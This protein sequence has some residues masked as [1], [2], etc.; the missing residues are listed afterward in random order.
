MATV[1]VFTPEDIPAA[2]ALFRRVHPQPQWQPEG[3]LESYFRRILFENPWRDLQLPSWAAEERGRLVGF[4]AVMP[5]RMLLSGRVLRVA[6]GCQFM[7]D[8]QQCDALTAF[9]LGKVFLSGPQ[10]L[11]LADGATDQSRRMWT[12]I[13][14]TASL[15][16]S[17]HW[18]RPLRPARYLLRLL[19]RHRHALRPLMLAA[20]PVTAAADALAAWLPPNRVYRQ[21]DGLREDLL[22]VPTML[23]CLPAMLDGTALRPLYDAHSLAWLLDE[24]ARKT[25]HGSLRGRAVLDAQNRAVG[26]YLYYARAG[27]IGEVLQVA[28][29]DGWFDR[30]LR[31]LL[32]DAWHAGAAAVRGRLDPRYVQEFSE[33][34]CWLRT[35]GT[36]T[37]VHSR[38]REVMDAIRQGK[39]GLSR[40][41]GEWWL[42]FVDDES[43]DPAQQTSGARLK[44]R[45]GATPRCAPAT[46][47]EK[48]IPGSPGSTM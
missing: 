8:P 47:P 30:V 41:E 45:S 1:R 20:R 18:T 10:D 14:G 19:E 29:A 42:R 5:R 9:R 46:P 3:G 33:R 7:V 22:D 37:L 48:S 21:I 43:S 39:A 28:A 24:A 13:G 23:Q 34:H 27:G 35:E 38:D 12:A 40:L 32:A 2:C 4:Y 6:V 17:L 26:W 25:R 16:Y 15:L 11:S 36:W 31:R 44:P